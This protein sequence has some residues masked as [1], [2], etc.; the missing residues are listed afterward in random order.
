M[1]DSFLSV[2]CGSFYMSLTDLFSFRS[3]TDK[4]YNKKR[5]LLQEISD[6]E[7]EGVIV[8]AEKKK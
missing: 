3:R 1:L 5:Q 8:V 2:C 4:E 7:H 6:L